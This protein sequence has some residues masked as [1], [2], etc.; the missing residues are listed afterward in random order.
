MNGPLGLEQGFTLAAAACERSSEPLTLALTLSGTSARLARAGRDRPRP[1]RSRASR[2]SLR[3]RASP[4]GRERAGATGPA[5]APTARHC[6][7]TSRTRRPLSA[8]HRP[9]ARARKADRFGWPGRRSVRPLGRGERRHSRRRCAP[10]RRRAFRNQGSAYVF[11]KPGGGWVSG[12]RDGEAD[13]LGRGRG[14]PSSALPSP[15]AATRSSSGRPATT[16]A[17]TRDQGSAYVFVKPGGGW[18]GA[19]ETAKLTASDGA[20]GDHSA[21][22]PPSAATRSS[23]E[24]PWT[25]SARQRARAPPTSSSSRAAAGWAQPR[26]RS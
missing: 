21:P 3:Y 2:A 25:T 15:S 23:S 13:R 4:H 22:P 9:L 10:G 6:S 11:V 16:S 20:A 24:R 8:H 18:V 17:R 19:T 5:R 14:R 7:C 12:T 26:R 1:W